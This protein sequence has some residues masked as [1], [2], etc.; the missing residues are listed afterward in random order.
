MPRS[1]GHLLEERGRPAR[2]SPAKVGE[3]RPF[4][5]SVPSAGFEQPR[6]RTNAKSRLNSCGLFGVFRGCP[7]VQSDSP[8]TYSALFEVI[9]TV[10][11]HF[12]FRLESLRMRTP[13]VATKNPL[14]KV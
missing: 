3:T 8:L 4:Q 14:Q 2:R 11:D 12:I 1:S 9:R 10:S 13:T 5:F 7:S 6:T